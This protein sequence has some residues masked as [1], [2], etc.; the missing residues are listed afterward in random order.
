MSIF[1]RKISK[2]NENSS[3]LDAYSNKVFRLVVLIVPFFFLCG[4]GT[5]TVMHMMGSYEALDDTLMWFSNSIDILYLITAIIIVKTSYGPDGLLIT[6]RL[7]MAKFV[8]MCMVVLQWNLNSYICPFEDF[9]AYAPLFVIIEAFFFDVAM[10]HWTTLLIILSMIISWIINGENLLPARDDFFMLNLM[11]R[12]VGLTF[13]LFCVN[14]I[15]WFGKVFII[16]MVASREKERAFEREARM[17]SDFLANMSH[18]IRTPMNAVIGMAEL[19]LR[20]DLPPNAVD[21]LNQIQRSGRNL[22]NIINDILDYSKIDSGKLEII[23]EIY[24][25]ASEMNDI[26]NILATRIEDK[27]LELFILI[28]KNVPH[29]LY[30]DAMRI[31]QVI[32]NLANNAIKFTMEGRVTVTIGCENIDDDEVMLTFHIKDTGIGISEKDMGKLFESFQ[33]VDS[34]RNRYVEGTG[35]GL[36]ISKSLIESMGGE[37]GVESEYGKGSDFWFTIPQKVIDPSLDLEIRDVEKKRAIILANDENRARSFLEE[38]NKLGIRNMYINNVNEYKPEPGIKDYL[39]FG[40]EVS[41]ETVNGFLENNLDVKGIMF[42]KFASTFKPE[43]ENLFTMRQPVSTQKMVRM[44]NDETEEIQVFSEDVFTVNFTAPTARILIVDDNEINISIAE[45][46]LAPM[47]MQ[48]DSAL[49][50]LEAFKKIQNEDYDIVLMDHM[51]PGMDGVDTTK[52]IRESIPNAK[53]MVIIALSANA[54]K[55]AREMF[56]EAGMDDFVAKPIEVKELVKKIRNWLPPEKVIKGVASDISSAEDDLSEF[57]MLDTKKAVESLGTPALFKKIAEE[58]YKA[59]QGNYDS[60]LSSFRS[61]SIDDF[62]IRVHALKSSSRQIGA[63]ELGDKAEA[64]E[65]AGKSGDKEFIVANTDDLLAMYK[66]LLQKL[67]ACFPD[68]SGA[69]EDLPEISEDELKDMLDKIK[70]ACDEFD[71]DSLEEIGAELKKYSWPADKHD[72][73]HAL[74]SAIE[75]MEVITCE[76]ILEKLL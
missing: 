23:P 47:N 76:E 68:T 55:E 50:G 54:L 35:L 49:S 60:I 52:L 75:G 48:I 30:G 64:L 32:I 3:V 69:E 29:A 25:P 1:N 37:I 22:L 8:L 36:A 27:E 10:V 61:D 19:A 70:A 26:S 72:D 43:L 67:S 66:D 11:F 9:W 42:V 40:Y 38:T 46:L 44:L 56:L 4:N 53:D 58:Y 15:T 14:I 33:Q 20:E 28:D 16:E 62:T 45:G 21:C 51:M 5:M 6:S 59:G 39:F 31:R 74:C 73:I 7:P 34:R 63:V 17:K 18:E 41:D 13:T 12:G 65:M 57:G 71:T 2:S 24:E